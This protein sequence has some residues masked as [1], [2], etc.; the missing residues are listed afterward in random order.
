[1]VVVSI[2]NQ[3]KRRA[4][5]RTRG[6]TPGLAKL[7]VERHYLPLM[8]ATVAL[9]LTAQ[10]A[11]VEVDVRL[12]AETAVVRVSYQFQEPT[13]VPAFTLIRLPGQVIW[14]PEDLAV[15]LEER[16]GL[17]RIIGQSGPEFVL[18]YSVSGS[19]DRIPI[20]VPESALSADGGGARIVVSGLA[21][22]ARFAA[23]FPRLVLDD[24]GTATARLANVPS[25]LRLP[26]AGRAWTGTAVTGTV[27]LLLLAAGGTGWARRRR[28]AAP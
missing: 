14:F 21:D 22:G 1:M 20:P 9:V 26:P 16:E 2:G 10:L 4:G 15:E 11:A 27:L 18:R 28:H 6:E 19:L 24:K 3:A 17:I 12:Q 5:D 23:G 13:S 7:V 8:L 25:L